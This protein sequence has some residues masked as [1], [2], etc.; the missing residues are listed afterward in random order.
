MLHSLKL[1]TLSLL[2]CVAIMG[3]PSMAGAS[4]IFQLSQ[5]G[6][7][8]TTIAS[9]ASLSST[10]GSG[11]FGDFTFKV[12]GVSTDNGIT[13]SDLL[14]ST[15]SITNN[16]TATHSISILVSSQDYTLPVGIGGLRVE[17]GM[18]ASV[19][20]GTLTATFRSYADKNNGLG[21]MSDFSLGLQTCV[22]NGS[23]CDT[24]SSTGIF[25]KGSGNY[26]L[27]SVATLT[28]SGGGIG[29]FSTHENVRNVPEPSSL[30]LLGS[31]MLL[32]AGLGFKRK[33]A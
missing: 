17:S 18:G 4:T 7:A 15:T 1:L 10:S 5:D 26:S 3:L 20:A 28:L 13:L 21:A 23:T 33:K 8:Y 16:S 2:V 19:S 6:G 9:G 30:V 29:N 24:G 31:G 12:V 11:T 22:F 27:T 25:T 32:V 14:S